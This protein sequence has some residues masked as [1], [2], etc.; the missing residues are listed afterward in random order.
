ME[1]T[2][3]AAA[4]SVIQEISGSTIKVMTMKGVRTFDIGKLF[5]IEQESLSEEFSSQ[6]TMYGFFA[7][8][9]AEADR[10]V[11]MQTVLYE[12]ECAGADESYRSQ[13]EADGKKYT[14]AVIRSMVIRDEDVVKRQEDKENAEYD[15]NILKAIV[16]AFEQRSLMLQSLGAT[17]RHEY[18]MQGMN[19]R[20]HA[21]EKSAE[22]VKSVITRRRLNKQD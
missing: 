5:K 2:N 6:A 17:L 22:E 21:L 19:V 18:E 7:I 1:D 11:A 9:A 4:D 15:L 14:E 16:R 8:L 20:E 12:Q 13:L 3:K 10:K